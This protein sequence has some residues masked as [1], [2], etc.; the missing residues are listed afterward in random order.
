MRIHCMGVNKSVYDPRV[1]VFVY[2][3]VHVCICMCVY[4]CM[5][6]CCGMRVLCNYVQK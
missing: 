6:V 2:L 5:Y 3:Y 4:V 1:Y